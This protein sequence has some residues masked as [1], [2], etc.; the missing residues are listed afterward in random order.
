MLP[1][2]FIPVLEEMRSNWAVSKSTQVAKCLLL[3][4]Q[5]AVF[6]ASMAVA[7]K[8]CE[9]RGWQE[10]GPQSLRQLPAPARPSQC[11]EQREKHLE[12][13]VHSSFQSAPL[14]LLKPRAGKT[15]KN[16]KEISWGSYWWVVYYLQCGCAGLAGK[17]LTPLSLARAVV[18]VGDQTNT[19]HGDVSAT[20]ELCWHSRKTFSA[21]QDHSHL[22]YLIL[23]EALSQ[24][25]FLWLFFPLLPSR[26]RE[27]EEAERVNPQPCYVIK[28]Y[29]VLSSVILCYML[30]KGSRRRCSYLV[31]TS[32]VLF[33]GHLNSGNFFSSL[34]FPSF[35]P[36]L[37]NFSR[38]Q[39]K[40]INGKRM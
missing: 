33:K 4:A 31:W 29:P 38:A 17:G 14:P 8:G 11:S 35:S 7:I 2:T 26:Q 22:F 34:Y 21:P 1:A 10:Q 9:S 30:Q 5:V 23:N 15:K 28:C 18:W 36:R 27:W 6:R 24:V 3:L 37:W 13:V 39:E 19:D 16:H 32:G 12:R 25:F 20:A 40:S